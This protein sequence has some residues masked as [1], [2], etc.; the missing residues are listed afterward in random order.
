[1]K[2][3]QLKV[4]NFRNF[5]HLSLDFNS[6]FNLLH[7]ENGS[8]KTSLLEILYFLSHGKS[9]RSSLA[10]R[11]VSD[12]QQKFTLFS[13]L[14]SENKSQLTVGIE[15][16][17]KGDGEFKLLGEKT[18]LAEIT[19]LLPTLILNNDSFS[20]L[21]DGPIV[22]RQFLDWGVFHVKHS[23]I[24]TWRDYH[25]AL[26]QRNN[27]IKTRLSIKEIQNW[28]NI[29]ISAATLLTDF[30]Q[31][32]FDI[33]IPKFLSVLSNIFQ[34]SD[35]S[36]KFISGWPS[37]SKFSEKLIENLQRDIELG[38]TY[39][40]A[41]RADIKFTIKGKPIEDVL[42]RGQQKIFVWLMRLTQSIILNELTEK[43]PII[44]IDDLG[45]ELDSVRRE[46]LTELF[47][48]IEGQYFITAVNSLDLKPFAL[49]SK[50]FQM[51]HVKHD[52]IFLVES[53]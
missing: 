40:G 13:K 33:F 2:F 25:R 41:H 31:Q 53:V 10:R 26:K 44:L 49:Y 47:C 24:S 20:L 52:N 27:A 43:Q 4:D 17:I 19:A 8:G 45:A 37:E 3:S 46:A 48:N 39:Y 50:S 11:L 32:Y 22:R 16:D 42:S 28:D 6:R 1:M 15:K 34:F 9:F 23:F 12:S 14:T 38:Y 21:N 18:Q 30:R 29:L 7:G 36:I 35:L 51:F 5:P